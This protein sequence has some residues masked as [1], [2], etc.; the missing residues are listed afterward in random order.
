MRDK[1]VEG[2]LRAA[3]EVTKDLPISDHELAGTGRGH[4]TQRRGEAFKRL[5]LPVAG[6]AVLAVVVVGATLVFRHS[7]ES[8]SSGP[9]STGR[10]QVSGSPHLTRSPVS[11]MLVPGV[12]APAWKTRDVTS[13]PPTSSPPAPTTGTSR[14]SSATTSVGGPKSIPFSLYRHCGVEYMDYDGRVWKVVPPVPVAPQLRPVDGI[15]TDNGY[16]KGSIRVIDSKTVEFSANP[17][18]VLE[19][20][21]LTYKLYIGAPPTPGPCA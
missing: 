3:F 5:V 17:S 13:R 20:Y 21:V 6:A 9:V 8:A 18:A 14:T 12:P 2:R 15:Y 10:L 16:L 19:P 4:P 7:A 11:S 1:D